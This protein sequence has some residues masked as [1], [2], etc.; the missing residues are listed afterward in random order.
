ML[1]ALYHACP[2]Y[3]LH[4]VI[5]AVWNVYCLC[6]IHNLNLNIIILLHYTCMY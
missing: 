5:T 6:A 2:L 4:T 1:D 3:Y